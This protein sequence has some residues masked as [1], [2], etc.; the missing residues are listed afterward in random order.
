MCTKIS[1]AK[2]MF[3]I[4]MCISSGSRHITSAKREKS[5]EAKQKRKRRHIVLQWEGELERPLYI[6]TEKTAPSGKLKMQVSL[7]IHI[8]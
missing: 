8:I 4:K 1:K 6:K 5:E 2:Q 3:T 7:T